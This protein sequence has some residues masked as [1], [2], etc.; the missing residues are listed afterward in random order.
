MRTKWLLILCMGFFAGAVMAQTNVTP[1]AAAPSAS[2]KTEKQAEK[3]KA[4]AKKAARRKLRR[5]QPCLAL[6]M[7]ITKFLHEHSQK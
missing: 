3:K 6:S 7:D 1:A 4:P 5:F 2:A